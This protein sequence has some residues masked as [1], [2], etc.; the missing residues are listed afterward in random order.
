MEITSTTIYLITRLDGIGRGICEI[1][2]EA[3]RL[4]RRFRGR[5]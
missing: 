5:A 2:R 3:R 4:A 1:E